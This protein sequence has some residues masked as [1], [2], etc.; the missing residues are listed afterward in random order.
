MKQLVSSVMC[1]LVT[2]QKGGVLNVH[3]S[4]IQE[5]TVH[6]NALTSSKMIQCDVEFLPGSVMNCHSA[7]T[8]TYR[9]TKDVQY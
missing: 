3:E 2:A 1:I 4:T 7:S 5:N 6:R 8:Y 9:N